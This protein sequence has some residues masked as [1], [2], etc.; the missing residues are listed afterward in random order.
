MSAGTSVASGI[1]DFR[2]SGGI[3]DTLRPE[4]IAASVE[5]RRLMYADPT[6]VVS[7]S[8]F[9]QNQLPYLEVRRPF[10]FFHAICATT[11]VYSN[12]F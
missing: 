9:S 6:T 7:W 2:S 3:F 12:M 11:K 8:L 5:E 10:H 4:L 1:P